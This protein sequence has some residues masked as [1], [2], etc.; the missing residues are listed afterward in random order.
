MEPQFCPLRPP[1]RGW[2]GPA[3]LR[4]T[5]LLPVVCWK[6]PTPHPSFRAPGLGLIS[7]CPPPPQLPFPSPRD[8]L[9]GGPVQY[10]RMKQFYCRA[11]ACLSLDPRVALRVPHFTAGETEV[12]G[13]QGEE[14][15]SHVCPQPQLLRFLPRKRHSSF[16]LSIRQIFIERLRCAQ[17]SSRGSGCNRRHDR[18]SPPRPVVRYGWEVGQFITQTAKARSSEGPAPQI[19]RPIG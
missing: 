2:V 13:A 4:A 17:L 15:N 6:N 3:L 11:A 19:P 18:H 14:L 10:D 12:Q 9:A 8:F 7:L 5:H 1:I 16:R